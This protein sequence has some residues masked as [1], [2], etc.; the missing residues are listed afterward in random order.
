MVFKKLYQ[1][2][3]W[4]HN[5]SVFERIEAHKDS[6]VETYRLYS[7]ELKNFGIKNNVKPENVYD[8]VFIVI[9]EFAS[10]IDRKGLSI[11]ANKN[12]L[13]HIAGRRKY[14]Y[15]ETDASQERDF[16]NIEDTAKSEYLMFRASILEEGNFDAHKEMMKLFLDEC[17]Q[18]YIQ[19][20]GESAKKNLEILRTKAVTG[21]PIKHLAELFETTEGGI[22][23]RLRNVR[24]KLKDCIT[25]KLKLANQ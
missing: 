11:E 4:I 18:Q 24:G 19:G 13:L 22:D 12:L 20:G 7:S 14:R 5:E 10:V 6:F 15:W 21:S 2:D 8:F 25:Q 23:S 9:S 3:E 16:E 1:K 17:T